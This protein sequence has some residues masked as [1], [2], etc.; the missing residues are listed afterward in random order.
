MNT[1]ITRAI[2][3]K[4]FIFNFS[5]FILTKLK[6][7]GSASSLLPLQ[8]TDYDLNFARSLARFY[9][10]KQQHQTPGR[11]VLPANSP[12]TLHPFEKAIC[13]YLQQMDTKTQFLF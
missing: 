1:P 9:F 2:L 3:P 10:H 6:D 8:L 7:V 13:F 12:N 11:V 4:T 5:F